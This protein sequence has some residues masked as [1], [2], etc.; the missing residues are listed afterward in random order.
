MESACCFW[1]GI[2][3]NETTAHVTKLSLDSTRN[4]RLGDWYFNASLFLPFKELRKL[5]LSN[6]QLVDWAANEGFERLSGLN[7]LEVLLLDENG[8]NNSI[9]SSLGVLSPLKR[10]AISWNNLNGSIHL[11]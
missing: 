1:E 7:K 3:C 9:L 8:Y 11:Q 2:E 6:N 5:D 4:R 10:L